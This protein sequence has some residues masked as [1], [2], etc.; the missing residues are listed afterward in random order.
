[1]R[2]IPQYD[3]IAVA[4]RLE[5]AN[6]I[7]HVGG[8]YESAHTGKL[9]RKLLQRRHVMYTKETSD[10][11]TGLKQLIDAYYNT[12]K[13]VIGCQT[14]PK[15]EAVLTENDDYLRYTAVNYLLHNILQSR[16]V[17]YR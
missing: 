14:V 8:E 4:A 5:S 2:V 1:M 12:G 3:C 6:Y 16:Y 9:G 13:T 11:R 15:E 7:E 10:G 17:Y